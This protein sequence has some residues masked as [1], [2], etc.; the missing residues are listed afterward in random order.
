MVA[1]W[2]LRIAA[3]LLASGVAYVVA[4]VTLV[5]PGHGGEFEAAVIG[6]VLMA[7]CIVR[8][9]RLERRVPVHPSRERQA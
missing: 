8:S 5:G 7:L 3:I 4:F 9:R 2:I 1:V 6:V